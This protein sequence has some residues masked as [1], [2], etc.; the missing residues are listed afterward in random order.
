MPGFMDRIPRYDDPRQTAWGEV[1]VVD[2]RCDGCRMCV[3]V[4][5]GGALLLLEGKAR[6]ARGP[7]AA[8]IACADCVAICPTDALRLVRSFLY[9][10]S[11]RV[12]DK[13]ELQPP[14]L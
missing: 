8:C 4:C 2:G 11:Y 13:G 12:L 1:V 6:M 3:R 9:T 7:A 5:P 14:R 10:G